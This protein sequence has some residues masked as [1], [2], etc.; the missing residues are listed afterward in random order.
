MRSEFANLD[1]NSMRIALIDPSLFTLPY[2]AALAEGLAQ[3]GHQVRL[4]GR[5]PGNDENELQGTPLVPTFYK[6]ANSRV[7]NMLPG[8]LRLALK[9]ADHAA[10]MLRL[11]ALLARN[12]PD[13]IHF[14]WLPLP[15]LDRRF[16]P[17]L[18]R[19]A[20]LVLTVHD[21]QPFNGNPSA[22]LQS[23]GMQGSFAAFD[24]LIVHTTQGEARMRALGIDPGRL[25]VLP[26][27]VLSSAAG[28]MEDSM[29][30]MLT[31]VLFGKIKPYKGID[32][33]LRAYAA[34][35]PELRGQAR[36]HVVGKPYMDL[37]PLTT[38]ADELGI[39][40]ALTLEPRFASDAELPELFGSGRVAVFPY[41]EIE[42]S[43]VLG[44]AMTHGRPILASNLASFAE[45]VTNGVEGL[46][47]P[48]DDADALAKAMAQFITDRNFA[49][50][51]ARNAV[52]R[53]GMIPSWREI[54]ERTEI[55]YRAAKRGVEPPIPQ[56][57]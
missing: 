27:G 46:L 55:L 32:T 20:P 34:L 41:R 14:Q 48:A 26:H 1:R 8:P 7:G 40:G 42:A 35:P 9:G 31:F 15:V 47:V 29:T 30:G 4:Y 51:C 53:V 16:L 45:T 28:R 36:L 18:R 24:R 22:R 49:A 33:L 52:R 44:I 38:L 54:A 11:H 3:A 23:L 43:G 13:V 39:R 21:T 6:V 5:R 17:A 57:R 12:R 50:S 56:P 10:S 19:I 25:A 2:D 37:L